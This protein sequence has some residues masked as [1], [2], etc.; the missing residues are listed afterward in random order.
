MT[1]TERIASIDAQIATLQEQ[2]A[3]ILQEWADEHCP[4]KVGDVVEFTDYRGR[5]RR[6]SVSSVRTIEGFTELLWRVRG[7]QHKKNGKPGLLEYEFDSSE[8][9]SE[10]FRRIETAEKGE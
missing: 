10:W 4:F 6:L 1:T 8:Y 7:Y 2:R 9:R 5:G 3:S